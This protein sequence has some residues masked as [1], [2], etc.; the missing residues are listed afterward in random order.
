MVSHGQ[1]STSKV[2]WN[3]DKAEG[4]SNCAGSNG[5][6]SAGKVYQKDADKDEV[7]PDSEAEADTDQPQTLYSA[8][9][10]PN[11]L[12]HKNQSQIPPHN[13]DPCKHN[14]SHFG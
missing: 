2:H 3:E 13:S 12:M 14:N 7:V 10:K 5:Q 1:V 6:V 4:R 8:A 9:C 11:H